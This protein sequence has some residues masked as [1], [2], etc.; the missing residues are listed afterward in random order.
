VFFLSATCVDQI[1]IED[2]MTTSG[3]LTCTFCW[4]AFAPP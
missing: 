1:D 4:D 3:L 2:A